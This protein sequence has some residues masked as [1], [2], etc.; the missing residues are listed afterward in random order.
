MM[1]RLPLLMECCVYESGALALSVWLL[2]V[3]GKAPVSCCN[4][5]S[6]IYSKDKSLWL[7]LTD[8]CVFC[9]D[10]EVLNVLFQ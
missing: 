1:A 9:L 7:G 4:D 2:E 8:L 6:V 5:K 10:L 3:M